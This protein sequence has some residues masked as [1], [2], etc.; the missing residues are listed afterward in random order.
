[1]VHTMDYLLTEMHNKLELAQMLKVQ[2]GQDEERARVNI[3][4]VKEEIDEAIAY[5]I[6]SLRKRGNW[7]VPINL[8]YNLSNNQLGFL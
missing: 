7:Y 4:R 3:E 1:M 8:C 2:Y 5:H 6:E